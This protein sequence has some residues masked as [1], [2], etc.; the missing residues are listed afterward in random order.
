MSKAKPHAQANLEEEFIHSFP[1]AGRYLA[2]SRRQDFITRNRYWGR[3][4]PSP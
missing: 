3:Q 1:V 2:I 4:T